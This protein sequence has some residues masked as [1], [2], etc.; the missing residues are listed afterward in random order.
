MV[1]KRPCASKFVLFALM[2]I[3]SNSAFHLLEVRRGSR[4]AGMGEPKRPVDVLIPSASVDCTLEKTIE[5]L[6]SFLLDVRRIFIVLPESEIS[7]CEGMTDKYALQS[8]IT[9]FPEQSVLSFSDVAFNVTNPKGWTADSSRLGWYYQQLLKLLF[10]TVSKV[11]LSEDFLIWDSDNILL[12]PYSP[13]IGENHRFIQRQNEKC[14]GESMRN[15]VKVGQYWP[16]TRELLSKRKY[17]PATILSNYNCD[18]VVHQMLINKHVMMNLLEH[19]CGEDNKLQP[20]QCANIILSDIP[21]E[22][23]PSYALSEYELYFAWLSLTKP[24]LI[25]YDNTTKYKRTPQTNTLRCHDLNLLEES[26][27]RSTYTYAVV[28]KVKS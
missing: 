16:A 24:S 10:V 22:S 9:C 19:L 21:S 4:S 23:H 17:S 7:A 15:G 6:L 12:K 27:S 13:F 26:A 8:H 28:E 11:E 25:Q 18:C 3:V 14:G 1:V 2:L 20:T 5:R